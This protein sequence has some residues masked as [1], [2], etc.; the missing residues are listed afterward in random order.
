ML[1]LLGKVILLI[2]I[3]IFF[4]MSFMTKNK[5]YLHLNEVHDKTFYCTYNV[6]T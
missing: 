5:V 2:K 6:S 4:I 1:A 3:M